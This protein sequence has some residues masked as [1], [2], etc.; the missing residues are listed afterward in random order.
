MYHPASVAL[1]R[2][3]DLLVAEP[4][5]H[6][7]QRQRVGEHA[8]ARSSGRAGERSESRSTSAGQ[9][10]DHH[11][12][13]DTEPRRQVEVHQ[14][15]RHGVGAQ[16]E[17]RRMAERHQAGVAAQDIPGQSHHRPDRHQREHQ[18]VVL[19]RHE[20]RADR[21]HERE[22]DDRDERPRGAA[23]PPSPLMSAPRCGRT[24]PAAAPARSAGTRRRW[25][26]SAAGTAAPA[27]TAAA[28]VRSSCRPRTRR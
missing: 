17:E 5:E 3:R 28:P 25:R 23:C 14:Q 11:A 27:T 1:H 19:V 21:I 20:R 15:Q 9:R 6:V 10:A 26:R 7:E 24:G 8:T 22:H 18:L 13:R 16:P 4:L 2:Q 12:Q